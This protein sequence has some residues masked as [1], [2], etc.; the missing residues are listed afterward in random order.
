MSGTRRY[1]GR[2]MRRN[3]EVVCL[4]ASCILMIPQNCASRPTEIRF[5]MMTGSVKRRAIRSDLDL[6]FGV[7]N[8]AYSGR[9]TRFVYLGCNEG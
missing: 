2:A 9:K 3:H 6:E 4:L 7:I 1:V 8:P 5:D